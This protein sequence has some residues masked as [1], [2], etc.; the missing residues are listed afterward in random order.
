VY[1]AA[2]T[3]CKLIAREHLLALAGSGKQGY[4]GMDGGGTICDIGML[5]DDDF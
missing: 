4:D 5:D 1:A 2:K 3:A